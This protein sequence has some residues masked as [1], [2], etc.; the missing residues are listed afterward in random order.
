MHWTSS[1]NLVCTQC[2]HTVMLSIISGLDKHNFYSLSCLSAVNSQYCVLVSFTESFHQLHAIFGSRRD[3]SSTPVLMEDIHG[4]LVRWQCPP[5][6]WRVSTVNKQ[7]KVRRIVLFSCLLMHTST[8][9]CFATLSQS[10]SNWQAT[11]FLI[12][13]ITS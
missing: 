13:F 2:L 8:H 11:I 3:P 12:I 5:D 7:F 1:L 9:F 4:H 10:C 6:K